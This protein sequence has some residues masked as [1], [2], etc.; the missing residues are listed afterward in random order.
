MS[1]PSN[2]A[3]T[4]V[5]LLTLLV[6]AG[7]FAGGA[8][9]QS[10]PPYVGSGPLL[11][12]ILQMPQN[13]W[14]KVNANF[15]SDV[16]TP[17]DLEPLD[18]GATASRRRPDHPGVEQLRVGQQPRRPDHLRRGPRQLLGQRRL[19]LALQQ[20]A[21]G[22]RGAA[23]RDTVTDPVVGNTTVDGVD[24][25]PISSHT[26]DNNIFLPIVDRFM[27]WGGAAYDNGQ[28][29]STWLGDAIRRNRA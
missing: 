18:N 15:Y 11:P 3:A 5:R 22:A 8:F 16:W 6:A 12:L 28:S 24:N 29:Y 21:V 26:Y 9:G 2:A 27:T 25:A 23:Q 13:S 19:S 20:S 1:G 17:A 10:I 4:F 14:L 7:L